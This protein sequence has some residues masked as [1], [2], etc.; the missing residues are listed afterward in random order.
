MVVYPREGDPSQKKAKQTLPREYLPLFRLSSL[1]VSKGRIVQRFG[2]VNI[3]KKM[4]L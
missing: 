3:Q 4:L 2:N 1:A